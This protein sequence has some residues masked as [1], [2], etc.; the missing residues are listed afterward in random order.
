MDLKRKAE[1]IKLLKENIRVNPHDLGLG[2]GFLDITT[3][4]TSSKEKK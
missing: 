2:N 4:S 3:K 1:T